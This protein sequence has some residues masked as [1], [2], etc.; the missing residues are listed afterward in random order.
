[1]Q[2]L[3]QIVLAEDNAL[4][5]RCFYGKDQFTVGEVYRQARSLAAILRR[6]GV[7]QGSEQKVLLCLSRSPSLVMAHLAV[8]LA[9]GVIVPVDARAP[10]TR[11][12]DIVQDARPLCALVQSVE[13]AELF[14]AH[15]HVVRMD[16]QLNFE[17][18]SSSLPQAEPYSPWS[19]NPREAAYII[20]TSGTTGKPK[21]V[22]VELRS[23]E[24]LL[25]WHLQ[26]FVLTGDDCVSLTASPG[27]DASVW[28]IWSVLASRASI[29]ICTDDE[30]LDSARL[31]DLWL[32]YGVTHAFVS[33]P[34]IEPLLR[35][36]WSSPDVRVRF[37]LTGGDRLVHRPPPGLPFQLINNYGPSE[38][39]V[40]ATSECVAAQTAENAALPPAIGYPL[41]HVKTYILDEDRKPV[42]KGEKGKLWIGGVALAR[43]YLNKADLT[44]E[45][46]PCDPFDHESAE[47]IYNTGDIVSENED[48]SLYYHG[49]DDFQV[50][51]DGVRMELSEVACVL[52]LHPRVSQAVA[53]VITP[54]YPQAQTHLLVCSLVPRAGEAPSIEDLR[55]FAEERLPRAM[56]P[57]AF[58]LHQSLPLTANGK[59][60]LQLLT[61]LHQEEFLAKRSTLFE[62]LPEEPLPE[63]QRCLVQIWAEVLG[64]PVRSDSDLFALGGSSISAARIAASVA[65]RFGKDCRP[66][67]VLTSRTPLALTTLLPSLPLLV[68]DQGEASDFSAHQWFPV[69]PMQQSL[70]YLWKTNPQN[71]FYNVGATFVIDG[72]IDDEKLRQALL[73][74]LLKHPV[75]AT[76]F[77][78]N[79]ES[80]EIEQN[81]ASPSESALLSALEF[82]PPVQEVSDAL[83][84]AEAAYRLPFNIEEDLLVRGLYVPT[85]QGPGVFLLVCHHIVADGL[86]LKILLDE[87]S[88]NYA[89]LLKTEQRSPVVSQQGGE[90]QFARFVSWHARNSQHPENLKFWE[91]KAGEIERCAFPVEKDRDEREQFQ[92]RILACSSQ[93]ELGGL[94]EAFCK[95]Q[96]V[97]RFAA[98]LA[99]WSITLARFC[100]Q[101]E[102]AVGVPF[103]GRTHPAFGNTVGMFVNLVPLPI[104]LEP[105]QS[106]AA[107]VKAIVNELD[108]ALEHGDFSITNIAA[109]LRRRAGGAME[110]VNTT[111]SEKLDLTFV[112]PGADSTFVE[113]DTGGARFD[114]SAFLNVQGSQVKGHVE[115]ATS[116]FTEETVTRITHA[117]FMLL[118][119]VLHHPHI[120]W[121][122]CLPGGSVHMADQ[123]LVADAVAQALPLHA[124]F[125]QSVAQH[126]DLPALLSGERQWTYRELDV[127]V[128]TLAAALRERGVQP[129]DLVPLLVDRSVYMVMAILAVLKLGGIYVPL[130]PESPVE[131]NMQLLRTLEARVIASGT[132]ETVP[133]GPWDEC[134]IED[135]LRSRQPVVLLSSA[136][137][138]VTDTA[139]LMFTSGSTGVPKGVLCSHLGAA[140]RVQWQM[141][142]HHLL[143]GE[144]V[145]LKTPY[146]FD[147]SVWELFYSLAV[148]ATLVIA[149]PGMQ[150]DPL[151]MARLLA[152]QR[153]SLCHFVPAM[154]QMFLDTVETESFLDLSTLRIIHT[155]GEALATRLVQRVASLL[156][157]VRV[158]NLYGPTEA[159][160]EVTCYDS[161]NHDTN[162]VT[163]GCALPHVSIL[164]ADENNR[165]VPEGFPGE[166]L[167]GGPALARGYFHLPEETA[168]RFVDLDVGL[169]NGMSMFYKTGD[170]VRRHSD[171]T[172]EFLGRVDAQ[173]K[174]RGV[175]IEPEE[176][177]AHIA[178]VDGIQEAAVV[179]GHTASGLATLVCFYAPNVSDAVSQET[180]EVQAKSI[181][182]ALLQKLPAALVP[183]LFLSLPSLPLTRSG[184]R[185]RKRLA[186]MADDLLID[187]KETQQRTPETPL[188]I[189]IARI[190]RQVL[191]REEI[192]I[193]QNFFELGGDSVKAL[194]VVNLLSTEQLRF[195]LR[196]FFY[197]STIREQARYFEG[198]ST[199]PAVVEEQRPA[200]KKPV[201]PLTPLQSVMLVEC[202]K[203]PRVDAYW[204]MIAYKLPRA[205]SSASIKDAWQA[206]VRANPAI[207]TRIVWDAE[208]SGQIIEESA[209]A[210]V[211]V[212]DWRVVSKGGWTL[213]EW[214]RQQVEELK[215]SGMRTLQ[216]VLCVE[217]WSAWT[218]GIQQTLFIWIHHHILIDGWSL[219]QCLN[220]F[221][222]VLSHAGATIEQR[223]SLE[224][225][226][227]WLDSSGHDGLSEAFWKQD[228]RGIQPA[229]T[230]HF[231]KP[232]DA[233]GRERREAAPITKDRM[234]SPLAAQSL[235]LFCRR[236][237]LTASSVITCLWGLLLRQYQENDDI[238]LGVTFA[239]RPS[240]LAC[241]QHL[242]G[243]LINTL[244]VRARFT[245]EM[246]FSQGCGQI[247]DKLIGIAEYAGVPYAKLLAYANLPGMTELF[248]STLVFQNFEGDLHIASTSSDSGAWQPELL[249]ARGTSTD[250]LSLTLDVRQSSIAVR[251]GWDENLYPGEM[252]VSLVDALDYWLER[253]DEIEQN[254]FEQL[255]LVTPRERM[256]L[257]K[258]LRPSASTLST[259]C[260]GRYLKNAQESIAIVDA[261][262]RLS[263]SELRLRS[264]RL[265]TCLASTYGLQRGDTVAYIGKRSVE[266]AIAIC[267]TWLLGAA[268]C[269]LDP[270]LPEAYRQ[271][272]L[273]AL[274]PK[275]IL[276]LTS[277]YSLTDAQS[278]PV[279]DSLLDIEIAPEQVVYYISTSGSTGRPKLVALSAGGIP[280]VIAAWQ[281]AYELTSGPQNVLQIGSWTSDVFL[282][283]FLKVISTSGTLVICPDDKRIDMSYLAQLIRDWRITLA[284][285]TPALI[286]SLVKHLAAAS[287]RPETLKTLIV[288]ADIFRLEELEL[289]RKKL[290]G[291]V[292]LFNGY[293]L[294]ECTIESIVLPCSDMETLTSRSGLCPL[295]NPLAG[296]LLKVVD[297][298]G[299]DVPPGAVG[300]LSI[301]GAQVARGYL[302][303]EGLSA[304]ERF[305]L[306]DGMRYFRTG[307]LV[308]LNER[309]LLEFFGRRDSQVK[310]RGYRVELG[311]IENILLGQQGI[312]EAA[313]YASQVGS[314][315]QLVAFLSGSG[316]GDIST[317]QNRLRQL[318]PEYAIPQHFIV[319]PALP[320]N[321]NGKIDRVLLRQQAVAI[322]AIQ[323][324][325]D[326]AGD[327]PH[328]SASER[329]EPRGTLVEIWQTLLKRPIR[330][331]RSFFDQGGHSLLVLQLF[332]SMKLRLPDD[333]F[334]IA[335]LFRY[336]TIDALTAELLARRV[337]REKLCQDAP[338]LQEQQPDT[339]PGT[340][341]DILQRL[342]RGDVSPDEALKLFRK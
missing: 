318:L 315:L 235:A 46:F 121:E 34:L 73:Q 333:E 249:F 167:L 106:Y 49:R 107:L 149:P 153:V 163:I 259:W 246:N 321:A 301:G 142:Q 261:R 233:S 82:R 187:R 61:R 17:P 330:L 39:C 300:E 271:R 130:D 244:P 286:G 70:W 214:C 263:Y 317:M 295:G 332:E 31:K 173:V 101:N 278:S 119:K 218:A 116:L 197:A 56:V 342:Q 319:L 55:T 84:E 19:R 72:Y 140:L 145:L 221:F 131:R 231:E 64:L 202:L 294:S 133:R 341:L 117:Y 69:T 251:I 210:A 225:Y 85:K 156:P 265:A 9:G 23:L 290:W 247:L 143:P 152:D 237:H 129:G 273:Q 337:A 98:M 209:D 120:P 176:I 164:L 203:N 21:G 38:G 12:S 195:P 112:L 312:L 207:R 169:G 323:E 254:T 75:I 3:K 141:K 52:G 27:F 228:L 178:E 255:S 105:G 158:L 68:I 339:H 8:F 171:G 144:R 192:G 110:L 340:L 274:K 37:V 5:S 287:V 42:R 307:D 96:G 241:A 108:S 329:D 4:S 36:D 104:V 170:L 185:D 24:A 100:H 111:F 216:K 268:W 18:L 76:R 134:I 109:T 57:A 67:H 91:E 86:S 25:V 172:L 219:A 45:C 47:R 283:D 280:Q 306:W 1:M 322:E 186:A 161:F 253:L 205:I 103:H 299:Y 188:E 334:E 277:L 2:L 325:A 282:G 275:A 148:G 252:I 94:L 201:L 230:L 260:V 191:K 113:V 220:D 217:H 184:K 189:L 258:T 338:A 175:R 336:P 81:I 95:E 124:L 264:L 20:Y 190:W 30:R 243:M 125:E 79:P 303:D 297:A 279:D 229:E 310:I 159:G 177:E 227:S 200:S 127:Q 328:G 146:T 136:Q 196:E 285:S 302:T 211:E 88:E 87:L 155:S 224:A 15:C 311:E 206:T 118:E 281:Q 135:A 13:H 63:E 97:S 50:K 204:Q 316:L 198:L 99:A 248:K 35:L 60:D 62:A 242:S 10:A 304:D 226:F 298:R 32:E 272:T 236:H 166:L 65:V 183:A 89:A 212:Y 291:T 16:E 58:M 238:C 234:L 179:A 66:S 194:Q 44:Q 269:A 33:T 335:D 327:S 41:P 7:S 208:Q 29:H 83:A 90:E 245:P 309:G 308:R 71:P 168:R 74:T 293:G 324:S 78:Q 14:A 262:R 51:I 92:G 77:R 284:E 115:Y 6:C 138:E 199:S 239:N 270:D 93:A 326:P 250:P 80:L 181:R 114:L 26:A 289:M 215:S 132:C 256:I 147:V 126:A 174:I 240:Q 157:G 139:Y 128:S 154:L 59:T 123:S 22:V 150:R 232:A 213:E 182:G 305:P 160:I 122:I 193:D 292:R 102:I 276:P 43:E 288:G 331:D 320:R 266:A 165:A 151:G 296:T 40:V 223:P 267:A 137:V 222:A 48:G 53:L 257:E 11:L 313:V 180:A 162:H 28:E 314:N 54:S